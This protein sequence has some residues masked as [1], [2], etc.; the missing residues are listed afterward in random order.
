[1]GGEKLILIWIAVGD[2]VVGSWLAWGLCGRIALSLWTRWSQEQMGSDAFLP[3]AWALARPCR[4]V[5]LS[6]F[7]FCKFEVRH[8]VR[9]FRLCV[10]SER[11]CPDG[12]KNSSFTILSVMNV[13]LGFGNYSPWEKNSM[14]MQV[15]AFIHTV[16][17][18]VD[19]GLRTVLIVVP[20]NVL[21]NW[22]SEF[23]KWQPP[24]EKPITVYMLEDVSR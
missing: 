24:N 3:T 9:F 5:Q 14:A 21:H 17:N 22:R 18:N 19:L 7:P 11:D 4:H 15:I 2:D 10:W 6:L 8:S 12:E 1:M 20:V 16:L 23:N 13:K